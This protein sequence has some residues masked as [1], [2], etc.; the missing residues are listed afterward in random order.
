MRCDFCGQAIQAGTVA[1]RNRAVPGS[2]PVCL[3]CVKWM[4]NFVLENPSVC[5]TVAANRDAYDLLSE[6]KQ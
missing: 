1:F 4:M 6:M 3:P 2:A 5:I